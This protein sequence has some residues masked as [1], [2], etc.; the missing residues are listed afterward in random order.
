MNRF[1]GARPIE[2][3]AGRIETLILVP[4]GARA[5]NSA[6]IS[7]ADSSLQALTFDTE[8]FDYDAMHSTVSNTGRLTCVTPGVYVVSGYVKWA[9][10]AT[11]VRKVALRFHDDSGA[12]DIYIAGELDASPGSGDDCEQNVSTVW[13]MEVDD[14]FELVVYQ[15]SG[16]ALNA[17]AC[18]F[19]AIKIS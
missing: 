6:A 11:G 18:E 19:D 17:T 16:G 9:A 12:S 8:R 7:V 5:Y 2:D 3:E 14:Y 10:D 1:L 15:D 13:A 4:L